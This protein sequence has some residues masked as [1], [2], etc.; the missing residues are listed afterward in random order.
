MQNLTLT[1]TDHDT[2]RAVEQ[3]NGDAD[4][5]SDKLE[6]VCKANPDTR[7]QFVIAG[8]TTAAELDW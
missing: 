1:I 2:G 6:S 7:F 5:I 8:T 3:F 4:D